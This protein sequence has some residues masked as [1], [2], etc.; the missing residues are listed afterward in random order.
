MPIN[1]LKAGVAVGAFLGLWHLTWAA[2]VAAGLAKWL[3]DLVLWMH[4]LKVE[5]S[6]APFDPGVAAVLVLL[7][8]GAG[9]VFGALLAVLWN[10]A[11]AVGRQP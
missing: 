6:V 11:H 3:I 10:R 8:S 7:T 4:F 2:L 5:V 1:P 9:F